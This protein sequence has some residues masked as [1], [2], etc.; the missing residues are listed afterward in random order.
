MRSAAVSWA[1]TPKE[2]ECSSDL[3]RGESSFVYQP[4]GNRFTNKYKTVRSVYLHRR[5]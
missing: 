4:C 1:W 3:T 2:K 5:P